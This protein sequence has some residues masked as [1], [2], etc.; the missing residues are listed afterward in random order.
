M[1]K[2]FQNVSSPLE[3]FLKLALLTFSE[4]IRNKNKLFQMDFSKYFFF[5]KYIYFKE[6]F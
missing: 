4:I 3:M 6:F 5:F 1:L 2:E